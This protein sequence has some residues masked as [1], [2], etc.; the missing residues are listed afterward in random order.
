[1]AGNNEGFFTGWS[2]L[3]SYPFMWYSWM[4]AASAGLAAST[5]HDTNT[6]HL[7]AASRGEQ[8][9]EG[10]GGGAKR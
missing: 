8:L 2:A 1:M 4:R 6:D 10:R 9:D 3:P 7:A 5:L